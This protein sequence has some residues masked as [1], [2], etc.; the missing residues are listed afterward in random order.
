MGQLEF[1][2][3]GHLLAKL[4][5]QLGLFLLALVSLDLTCFKLE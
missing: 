3:S 1:F 4:P 2:R 5:D